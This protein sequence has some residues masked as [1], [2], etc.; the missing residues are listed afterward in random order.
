MVNDNINIEKLVKEI[1]EIERMK[2]IIESRE[3]EIINILKTLK[4]SQED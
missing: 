2:I 1:Q 4:N 3:K